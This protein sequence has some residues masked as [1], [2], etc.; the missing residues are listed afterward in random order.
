[1][2][3]VASPSATSSG[4][5]V[6]QYRIDAAKTGEFSRLVGELEADAAAMPGFLGTDLH[7]DPRGDSPTVTWR[8]ATVDQARA[9]STSTPIAD[10][11]A[12]LGGISTGTPIHN[13]L[14]NPSPTSMATVVITTRVKPGS[15]AWFADWQGRMAA[16]QQQFPGYRGQRV[17]APVPGA[18]SDWV[19]IIA[20]DTN[21]NLLRW[22]ES[23][24]REAL[25]E[26]ST[27]YVERFAV[28][29]ADSA[30]ESWFAKSDGAGKPPPGWKLSAIVLLV[31][32][33][34][35]MLEFF[36]LNHITQDDLK[37]SLPIGVFI[38]NAISVAITGFF[39]IPWASKLLNWWLVPPLSE[40]RR[41]TTRGLILMLVLYAVSILVFWVIV[42]A[43]PEVLP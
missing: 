11:Q 30:F 33:P 16:A 9:W 22:Q 13:V 39:L 29:A 26:E 21:E 28:R 25:V 14:V 3:P 5:F 2:T 18:N 10:F 20:F 35:V 8:F 37:L 36:T 23:P 15:D 31:L 12:Q 38:G 7:F 19:A 27:P 1:M 40:A 43:F 34:I 4:S 41:R 17:Q 6:V 32:Y 42:R 24:E